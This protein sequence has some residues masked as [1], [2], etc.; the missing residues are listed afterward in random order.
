KVSALQGFK[1]FLEE[2]KVVPELYELRQFSSFVDDSMI[3][4]CA[5]DD[6]YGNCICSGDEVDTALQ[7]AIDEAVALAK[8]EE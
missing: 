3:L 5:F 6:D 4:H 1:K 8:S 2:Q 7:I